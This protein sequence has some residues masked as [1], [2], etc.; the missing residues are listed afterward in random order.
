M[1]SQT[2]SEGTNCQ[3]CVSGRM[4]DARL[5]RQV[6]AVF[7][8][9]I[10]AVSAVYISLSAPTKP[11]D[12]TATLERPPGH[13]SCL[14]PPPPPPE[15]SASLECRGFVMTPH[16]ADRQLFYKKEESIR[17]FSG[18]TSCGNH[19]AFVIGWRRAVLF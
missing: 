9:L 10:I 8:V 16:P 6:A 15:C 2:L 17:W 5:L 19:L 13:P 4:I 7:N 1:E 11:C 14:H 3:G 12:S 18:L